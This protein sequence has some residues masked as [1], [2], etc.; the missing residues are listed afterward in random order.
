MGERNTA[1]TGRAAQQ[2]RGERTVIDH[3]ADDLG[4][5]AAESPRRFGKRRGKALEDAIDRGGEPG[6]SN[7]PD[8]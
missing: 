7:L 4:R 1:A 3:V 8:F 6:K 2:R 5:P